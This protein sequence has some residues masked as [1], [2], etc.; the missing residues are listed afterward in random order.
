MVSPVGK[1]PIADQ[2]DLVDSAVV[3]RRFKI[4]QR[5]GLTGEAM[6]KIFAG[7]PV[8]PLQAFQH[9][10]D[11]QRRDDFVRARQRHLRGDA[12]QSTSCGAQT[13]APARVELTIGLSDIAAVVG[14]FGA[15]IGEE[16]PL[17]GTGAAINNR[18]QFGARHDGNIATRE[19]ES[20]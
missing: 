11:R 7:A 5:S 2:L 16:I 19:D 12:H 6:K 14:V 18:L 9:L 13:N 8:P 1:D 4:A 20:S 10:V 17:I 15:Q 3:G